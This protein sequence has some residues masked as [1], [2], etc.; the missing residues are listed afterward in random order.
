MSLF[1]PSIPAVAASEVHGDLLIALKDCLEYL[2][3]RRAGKLAKLGPTPSTNDLTNKVNEIID[4][5]QA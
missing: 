2:M 1:K 3:G 4:R 5:L